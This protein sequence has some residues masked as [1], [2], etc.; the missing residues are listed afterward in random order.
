MSILGLAAVADV[1]SGAQLR[2]AMA[3]RLFA[4]SHSLRHHG[5]TPPEHA[6]PGGIAAAVADAAATAQRRL[7]T[8]KYLFAR[9]RS[10]RDSGDAP[11]SDRVF[12]DGLAAA[13]GCAEA[14]SSQAAALDAETRRLSSQNG[15]SEAERA[16]E[17][18]APAGAPKKKSHKAARRAAGPPNSK[19]Q[20]RRRPSRSGAAKLPATKTPKGRPSARAAPAQHLPSAQVCG[21]PG[22]A[23]RGAAKAIAKAAAKAP[24]S[25]K[26]PV[27]RRPSGAAAAR[28][29]IKTIQKRP[30]AWEAPAQHLQSAQLCEPPGT[31]AERYDIAKRD[32]AALL[33]DLTLAQSAP[34]VLEGAA[35][36]VDMQ[37]RLRRA[38]AHCEHAL[39]EGD[40][41]SKALEAVGREAADRGIQLCIRAACKMIR[42]S[43]EDL[44]A[45]EPNW[46]ASEMTR[47]DSALAAQLLAK[48][49]QR[50][51][52]MKKFAK[53]AEET[54]AQRRAI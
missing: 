9:S 30:S 39:W 1:A 17:A 53:R 49:W 40:R 23:A 4:R 25:S 34:H 21:L 36:R 28:P 54:A 11:W 42:R 33:H 12:A 26:S 19:R 24:P 31:A 10:L 51:D 43:A 38:A 13:Q 2:T 44:L 29:V 6:F 50:I 3:Q 41:A 14:L 7:A 37:T 16:S 32:T 48:T 52:N 22:T 45:A 27:R 46:R 35:E 15:A 5:D 20:D 47:G 8:A 18:C